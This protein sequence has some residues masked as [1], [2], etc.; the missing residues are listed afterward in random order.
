M[1][2]GAQLSEIRAVDAPTVVES[3]IQLDSG[4]KLQ[5]RSGW[6]IGLVG[7]W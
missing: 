5:E 6:V 4:S 7:K 1:P 2:V 3:D